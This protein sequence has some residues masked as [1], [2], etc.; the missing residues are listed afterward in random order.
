MA[1]CFVSEIDGSDPTSLDEDPSLYEDGPAE[2]RVSSQPTAGGRV[3][4][5]FG[6]LGVDRQIRLRTDWMAQDTLDDFA[7]VCRQQE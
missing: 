7:S 6:T 3:W 4:Q 5:D 1:A 2:R